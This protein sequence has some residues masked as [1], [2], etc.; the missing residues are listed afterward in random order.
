MYFINDIKKADSLHSYDTV[1]IVAGD[2]KPCAG[3]NEGRIPTL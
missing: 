3:V 1:I 2:M